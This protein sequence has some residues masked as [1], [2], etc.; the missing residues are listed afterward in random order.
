MVGVSWRRRDRL[1]QCRT[2]TAPA[3]LAAAH[4][5]NSFGQAD[6]KAAVLLPVALFVRRL[7]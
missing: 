5:S 3:T 2:T 1:D 4:A 6:V 7:Q